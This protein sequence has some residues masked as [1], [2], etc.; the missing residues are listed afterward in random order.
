MGVQGCGTL[1]TPV[2]SMLGE[3]H[4]AGAGPMRYGVAAFDWSIDLAPRWSAEIRHELVAGEATTFLAIFPETS[5]ALLRL[6]TDEEHRV[7]DA[8]K[9][10]ELVGESNHARGR[11][12]LAA[13]CGDFAGYLVEFGTTDEW[14]RGWALNTD[15]V[16]LDATYRCS[17]AHVGRDDAVVDTMLNSLRLEKPSACR[18]K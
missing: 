1:E 9:W 17:L 2:A 5:D 11:R 3:C 4:F 16:P 18:P 6:T 8:A 15:C 12:V 7:T 14:L 10:V 13:R